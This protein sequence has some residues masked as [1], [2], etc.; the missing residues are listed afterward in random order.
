MKS[1]LAERANLQVRLE[2]QGQPSHLSSDIQRQLQFICREALNNIEKHAQASCV[3]IRVNWSKQEL[4]I[5]IEDDGHGFLPDEAQEANHFG[6]KIMHDRAQ[7]IH[8]CLTLNSA[9]NAGTQV[10][11]WVPLSEVG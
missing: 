4:Q 6:L 5:L 1:S 8:G 11:L 3:D 7:E 10:S 2:C 9:V